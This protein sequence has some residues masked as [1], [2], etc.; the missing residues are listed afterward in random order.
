MI[1]PLMFPRNLVPER[2]RNWAI[3][4]GTDGKVELA[5]STVPSALCPLA[6]SKPLA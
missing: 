2:R 5:M 4:Y 6:H 1:V 3:R